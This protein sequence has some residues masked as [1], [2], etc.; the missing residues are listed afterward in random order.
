M[1]IALLAVAVLAQEPVVVPNRTEC[2]R[3]RIRLTQVAVLESVDLVEWPQSMSE[4]RHGRYFVTQPNKRELP[5]VFNASGRQVAVLGA[6]GEG[7]GEFRN[8]ALVAVDPRTDTIFVTDWATSR[9]SVFSPQLAFV[10]SVPFPG[11]ARDIAVLSDGRIVAMASIADRTSVGLPFHMF[12]RDGM[13]LSAIG[14]ERRPYTDQREIFFAHRLAPSRRGGFWAVP[15][16]G[17]YRAEHWT[18]T[19]VRDAYLLRRPDWHS[20]LQSSLGPAANPDAMDPPPTSHRGVAETEDGLLWVLSRVADPG[21]RNAP[22]DTLRTAE[23]QFVV[24]ADPD[25]SWDS[26]LEVIDPVRGTLIA[27]QRFDTRFVLMLPSGKVIRVR[28]AGQGIQIQVFA[29]SLTRQ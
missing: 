17:E 19:G 5:I 28:E 20:A 26:V 11:R 4:D 6:S 1:N 27:S 13:R 15:I 23:G 8:A 14:D 21:R 2:P 29:I 3:C 7:P 18:A 16:W 10:R 9:L 12:R 25:R 24:G 22:L